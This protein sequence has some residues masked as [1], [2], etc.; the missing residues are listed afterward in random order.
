MGKN[1]FSIG[2]AGRAAAIGTEITTSVIIGALIGY[3][4]DEKLGTT[5]WMLLV[6]TGFGMVAA[7]RA[8]MRLNREMTRSGDKTDGHGDGQ[9]HH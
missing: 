6:W 4:L 2:K 1:Q 7:G 5:P 9:D 3:W 8:V